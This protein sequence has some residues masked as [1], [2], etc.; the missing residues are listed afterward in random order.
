MVS[1]LHAGGLSR[2]VVSNWLEVGVKHGI[3]GSNSLSMVIPEHLA[4]QVERLVRHQLVVLRVDKFGPRL[5][6]DRVTWQQFFVVRVEGQSVLVQVGEEFLSAENF[7][8]LDQLI[9]VLRDC[10]I[11][12]SDHPPK[13]AN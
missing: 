11:D 6:R 3:F 5:T 13:N 12:N 8:D 1:S 2:M 4:E 10:K 7:R 9:V